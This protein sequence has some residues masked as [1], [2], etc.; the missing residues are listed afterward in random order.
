M[1]QKILFI[2]SLITCYP[3]RICNWCETNPS[4]IL[5]SSLAKYRSM[6]RAHHA[7]NMVY[8]SDFSLVSQQ[9]KLLLHN[10]FI[11]MGNNYND[12]ILLLNVPK[13]Y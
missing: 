8:T 9:N 3:R 13:K 2:T 1:Y 12:E 11:K 5:L 7:A 6:K 4:P 10:I